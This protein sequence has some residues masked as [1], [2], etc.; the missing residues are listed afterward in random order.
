MFTPLCVVNVCLWPS[1]AVQDVL[2]EFGALWQGEVSVVILIDFTHPLL[3]LH[4]VQ[5]LQKGGKL[6]LPNLSYIQDFMFIFFLFLFK[7]DKYSY[8]DLPSKLDHQHVEDPWHVQSSSSTLSVVKANLISQRRRS[9]R[10]VVFSRNR[11]SKRFR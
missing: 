8:L 6:L 10:F 11:D 3:S 1:D 5:C 7:K 9:R 2:D 4:R